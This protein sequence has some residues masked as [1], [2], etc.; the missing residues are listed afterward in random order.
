MKNETKL[1]RLK[2]FLDDNS[3]GYIVPR[4]HGKR[5]HSDMEIPMYGICIKLQGEDDSLF[6]QKYKSGRY[7]VFIRTDETPK[8]IIE[9]VKNTIIKSMVDKQRCIMKTKKWN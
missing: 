3:I 2:R 8:F 6:F 7:P 1:L 9:K 4:K 5:G